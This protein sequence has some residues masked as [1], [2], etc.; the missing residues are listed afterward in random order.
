MT[1]ENPRNALFDRLEAKYR[2]LPHHVSMTEPIGVEKTLRVDLPAVRRR[3]F[4]EAR[5]QLL[6]QTLF[7]LHSLY[8]FSATDSEVRESL[9]GAI[10]AIHEGDQLCSADGD[11]D[12]KA[13][14]SFLFRRSWHET[15]PIAPTALLTGMHHLHMAGF[16]HKAPQELTPWAKRFLYIERYHRLD[17]DE[18]ENRLERCQALEASLRSG[19][20]GVQWSFDDLVIW[21]ERQFLRWEQDRI[22]S[23]VTTGDGRQP[24]EVLAAK[25]DWDAFL[26]KER[27]LAQL[28]R[29]LARQLESVLPPGFFQEEPLP[30]ALYVLLKCHEFCLAET[31]EPFEQ[32]RID[33]VFAKRQMDSLLDLMRLVLLRTTHEQ[34]I[35]ETGAILD[36]LQAEGFEIEHSAFR[37]PYEAQMVPLVDTER[38]ET[39]R[40]P[41]FLPLTALSGRY[42]EDLQLSR[43]ILEEKHRQVVQEL[44]A[45]C[46]SYEAVLS[47]PLPRAGTV[48][49]LVRFAASC[50]LARFS[51]PPPPLPD[52][53]A[54][55]AVK[56]LPAGA[57][58]SLVRQRKGYE[59]LS[60]GELN[61]IMD[62]EIR[63]QW[64]ALHR[65][66]QS[67]RILGFHDYAQFARFA[68]LRE[69]VGRSGQELEQG[70]KRTRAVAREAFDPQWVALAARRRGLDTRQAE[71]YSL[72]SVEEYLHQVVA[73][74][75]FQDALLSRFEIPEANVRGLMADTVAE[76]LPAFYN[77]LVA[78]ERHRLQ[79]PRLP[80]EPSELPSKA[81]LLVPPV[82]MIEDA[83]CRSIER[84]FAQ[85]APRLFRTEQR[86]YLI[87]AEEWRAYLAWLIH[88]EVG[89]DRRPFLERGDLDGLLDRLRKAVSKVELAPDTLLTETV[90]S[91][92][93]EL[94]KPPAE[95]APGSA[96]LTAELSIL[97]PQLN[98]AACGRLSCAEFAQALASGESQPSQCRH[99]T[100][101][102]LALAQEK[103]AAFPGLKGAPETGPGIGYL[104]ALSSRERYRGSPIR[105]VLQ[106]VL[107]AQEQRARRIFLERLKDLWGRLPTR[108]Q[109]FRCP[110]PEEFYRDLRRYMGYEA[111]ERIGEDERRYLI[112]H[113]SVRRSAEWRKLKET[114]D[115]MSFADRERQS[116]PR[117]QTLEPSWSAHRFYGQTFFLFQ[118][119]PADRT[120]LLR[121]RMDRFQ[122]GFSRWWNEDL[123]TMNLPDFKIRD[124][125]DF[126][127]I[128]T[129]AYWHQ[130]NATS[131]EDLCEE[132][133]AE[134]FSEAGKL[135]SAEIIVQEWLR[136]MRQ[137]RTQRAD[138]L[139]AH[140]RGAGP[141][142]PIRDLPT[143]RETIEGLADERALASLNAGTPGEDSWHSDHTLEENLAIARQELWEAFQNES[144]VFSQEFSCRWEELTSN[145]AQFLRRELLRRPANTGPP[146]LSG[147]VEDPRQQFVLS[148][149]KEPLHKRK[150]LVLAII[151]AAMDQRFQDL[152]EYRQVQQLLQLPQNTAGPEPIASGKKSSPSASIQ[153][154]DPCQKDS[155][156]FKAAALLPASSLKTLFRVMLWHRWDGPDLDQMV[157]ELFKNHPV[158][159]DRVLEAFLCEVIRVRRYRRLKRHRE[160]A[161]LD[162]ACGADRCLS[163]AFPAL[164][165]ALDRRLEESRPMDRERLL[166]YLFLLAR[167]E[168]NLESLT[169][170]LREIRE[171]SDV[172]E[173]AWLR[174]TQE[175]LW[176]APLVKPVPGVGLGIPLLAAGLKDREP[177]N[178]ALREGI[179]RKAQRNLASAYNELIQLIRFQV[180]QQQETGGGVDRV[181]QGL[182][183]SGYDL[184]PLDEAALRSAVQREWDRRSR[185][186]DQKIWIFAMATARRAASQLREVQEADRDFQ[187]IRLDL[188]KEGREG[189]EPYAD[190][191]GRRGVA[192]GQIKEQMYRQLSDLLEKERIASFQ[193]RIRQIVDQLDERREEIHRAWAEGEINRRTVFYALRQFQKREGEPGWDDFQRFLR[194]HWFHPLAQLR[195][196]RR[197]DREERMAELDRRFHSLLGTSLLKLETECRAAAVQEISEWTSGRLMQLRI[198]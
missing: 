61:A 36:A 101:D 114:Q 3:R 53:A 128:V 118:L 192:L 33:R 119:P 134:F 34:Q 100:P 52:D 125:E 29:E 155:P 71:H 113:G 37:D 68:V 181:M 143:L 198:P 4:D 177:L 187:T 47:Q 77:L 81:A 6:A 79:L 194:D 172:I 58:R 76:V 117:L 95:A 74:K 170:L 175:R 17:A 11:F 179:S 111:V 8:E 99:L 44:L 43:S 27:N 93:L 75:R 150:A 139:G 35:P 164:S 54:D 10:A 146:T 105:R 83:V 15:L 195:D 121:H 25:D 80:A 31:I 5:D 165:A 141:R 13:Y 48:H 151:S 191:L 136:G 82:G 22:R 131:T 55:Q 159:V 138:R 104:E 110:D 98:C 127:K 12:A 67:R 30:A 57:V 64:E 91:T 158:L 144:F 126:S 1:T 23:S 51:W 19:M 166:H 60:R 137:L 142:Q 140:R 103:L 14:A 65:I 147:G 39:T 50:F 107:S 106:G 97:L 78:Y 197:P 183:D 38:L 46:D 189:R 178:Q 70:L 156:G 2:I 16:F 26:N 84:E 176:E 185:Y 28:S 115:W 102:Q 90:E 168:G 109:I 92:V 152:A 72:D 132:L 66:A 56:L 135:Q 9:H 133:K 21:L 94:L 59:V 108:P 154:Q 96:E 157:R 73:P 180:L 163:D 149:W 190:I 171:T 161:G 123:L 153:N 63:R 193:K 18:S 45:E 24:S 148:S 182:L 122:D 116:R 41:L 169:A 32:M 196:S 7:H 69:A 162:I 130:E 173:A 49:R 174:F 160:A 167:M 85:D 186:Q 188:L 120:L 129:N 124:W 20:P 86:P 62:G 42:R 87:S 112:E 88:R 184:S 89:G 145:E 40:V